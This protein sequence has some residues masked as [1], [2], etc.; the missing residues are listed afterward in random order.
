[1]N[2]NPVLTLAL[3][4]SVL[5]TVLSHGE[6]VKCLAVGVRKAFE[7]IAN[8]SAL[9]R[10]LWS[11][12]LQEQEERQSNLAPG[13]KPLYRVATATHRITA[14]TRESLIPTARQPREYST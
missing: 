9:N 4:S 6:T 14:H 13:R 7:L 8:A 5:I 3:G 1:M 11:G 12:V 2:I 10:P